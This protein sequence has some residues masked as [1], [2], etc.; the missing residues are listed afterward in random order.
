MKYFNFKRYK[1]FPKINTYY[2]KTF[3]SNYSIISDSI[4]LYNFNKLH[5]YFYSYISDSFKVFRRIAFKK[6][7]Y[8]S[9]YLLGFFIFIIFTYLSLPFF[10][11]FNKSNIQ[12]ALCQKTKLKCIIES[13]ISYS[14]FPSPRI[15]FGNFLI[16]DIVNNNKN[17]AKISNVE[18]KIPFFNLYNKNKFRFN[19]VKFENLVVDF[20]LENLKEYKKFFSKE[21]Y[22]NK[23][24][25]KGGNINFVDGKE[26]VTS[27]KKINLKYV[28][29]KNKTKAIFKGK[30]ID[31]NIYIN[32]K[33]NNNKEKKPKTFIFKL[34]KLGFLAKI[35]TFGDQLKTKKLITGNASIKQGKNKITALFDYK[36]DKIF[37]KHSNLRT[38]FLDGKSDGKIIL[39]PYFDFNLNFNLNS[40]NFNKLVASLVS[41]SKE[42]K[43]KLFRINKKINGTAN[44]SINKIFS[45]HTL[46]HALESELRFINGNI[47]L[48]RVL[49]DL[50]KIGAADLSGSVKNGKNFSN[51]QFDSNIFVDNL[52]KLFSKFGIYNEKKIPHSLFVSGS[53][54][55]QNLLLRIN[56]ITGEEKFKEADLSYIQREFN[57]ILLENGYASLFNFKNFKTFFKSINIDQN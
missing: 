18:V 15:K 22:S 8:L 28:K 41:L 33:K 53:F 40:V 39:L 27:V 57:Q 55:L 31:E 24:T 6:L 45:R 23:I 32:Y 56:E 20:N 29:T 47:I 48:E 16:K 25:F 7:R 9:F 5:K 52:K 11:T 14:F 36:D 1:F 50:G 38:A 30:I 10:Y 49:L 2:I 54:D 37:I 42:E 4:K 19:E 43:K 26:F 51:F 21:L 3:I 34:D 12:N 44:I 13:N 17:L 35:N 46:I